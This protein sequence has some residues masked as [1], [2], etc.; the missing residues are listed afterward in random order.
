MIQLNISADRVGQRKGKMC[1]KKTLAKSEALSYSRFM[2]LYKLREIIAPVF[3]AD[4]C[5]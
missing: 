4:R 3:L 1:D 2:S 5:F